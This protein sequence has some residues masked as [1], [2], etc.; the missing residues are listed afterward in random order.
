VVDGSGSSGDGSSGGGSGSSGGGGS[1][2]DSNGSGSGWAYAG[3]FLV[4]RDF[5]RYHEENPPQ[6]E[7]STRY[8]ARSKAWEVP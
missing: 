4:A 1:S 6:L 7:N 3:D 8:A 5:P 2:G